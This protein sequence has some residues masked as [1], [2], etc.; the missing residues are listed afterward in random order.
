MSYVSRD[1]RHEEAEAGREFQRLY[2]M[3]CQVEK[4]RQ[5]SAIEDERRRQAHYRYCKNVGIPFHWNYMTAS[6]ENVRAC[7]N[8][9]HVGRKNLLDKGMV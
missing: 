1:K 4:N 9:Y 8:L 3:S 6:P 7:L 5:D 2:R